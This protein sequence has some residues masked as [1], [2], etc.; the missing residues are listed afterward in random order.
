MGQMALMD[1]P[2]ASEQTLILTAVHGLRQRPAQTVPTVKTAWMALT[3]KASQ[4]QQF[5][6]L[7]LAAQVA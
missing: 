5:R 3:V 2:A 4:L 1:N 7:S 6:C